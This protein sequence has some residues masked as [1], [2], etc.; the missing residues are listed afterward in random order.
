M[1]NAFPTIAIAINGKTESCSLEWQPQPEGRK[2]PPRASDPEIYCRGY[3]LQNR[4][5]L[6]L[7]QKY[8]FV[9]ELG[10]KVSRDD[11]IPVR[12]LFPHPPLQNL[13]PSPSAARHWDFS[14]IAFFGGFTPRERWRV[15]KPR[16]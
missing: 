6:F 15:V 10:K 9:A 8:S 7:R 5:S 16:Q 4:A 14:F 1:E 2:G 13:S 12:T 11:A 3:W